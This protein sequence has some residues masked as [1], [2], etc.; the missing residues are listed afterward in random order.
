MEPP[1]F[2]LIVRYLYTSKVE[3]TLDNMGPLM[4]AAMELQLNE[5]VSACE[6]Y[7]CK[8]IK[9]ETVYDLLV[10]ARQLGLKRLWSA[11]LGYFEAHA[12]SLLE[13]H[14]WVSLDVDIL[15]QLLS[16]ESIAAR[17][18]KI[19][20]TVVRYA[21]HK[22]GY[23]H[24]DCP[25]LQFPE[26]PGRL[27]VKVDYGEEKKSDVS[28]NDHNNTGSHDQSGSKD[29]TSD[30]EAKASAIESNNIVVTLPHRRFQDLQDTVGSMLPVVRFTSF[31]ITDF[32]RCVEGTGLVPAEICR[33]VYCRPILQRIYLASKHGFSA[34]A[35]HEHCDNQGPTLTIAR[36]N[37]GYVVGGF[38]EANWASD[39]VRFYADTNF[40]FQYSRKT[41]S[42]LQATIH[43]RRKKYAA[44][45]LESE[46]PTF[47]RHFDLQISGDGKDSKMGEGHPHQYSYNMDVSW[48]T[49]CF[50]VTDYEVFKIIPSS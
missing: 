17:E 44:Y 43:P 13:A 8:S 32:V 26:W 47:G 28:D 7:A 20:K 38:N 22:N 33:R 24:I 4:E 14:D 27:L 15:T 19:W 46:G 2:D 40:L 48:H 35:F 45:G 41:R 23:D 6:D 30:G 3:V 34:E 5:L 29:E 9:K 10:F 16:L 49:G 11:A 25:L 36:T 1:I 42:L 12:E 31:E 18:L 37:A 21:C 39:E 50:T